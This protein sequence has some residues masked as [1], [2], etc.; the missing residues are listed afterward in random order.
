MPLSIHCASMQAGWTFATVDKRGFRIP[1]KGDQGF[2]SRL[3]AISAAVP[4][5]QE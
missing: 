5:F 1:A 4:R 3:S 2:P